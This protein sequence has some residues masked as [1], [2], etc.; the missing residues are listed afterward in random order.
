M[1]P[2][3]RSTACRRSRRPISRPGS[4]DATFVVNVGRGIVELE[5]GRKLTVSNGVFEVPDTASEIAAGARAAQGRGPVAAAAELV[6]LDRLKEASG[7]P[8]DPATSR[9]NFVGQISGRPAD[10]ERSAQERAQ[11]QHRARCL[12][13]RRRQDDDGPEGRGADAESHGQSARHA[14]QGRRAH[15]RRSRRARLSQSRATSPKPTCASRSCSTT[16]R[17]RA[18]LRHRARR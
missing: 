10:H 18:R 14:D 2:C 3:A 15:Q 5:S 6:A 1:P 12:E 11:L 13:F 7:A 4:R 17:A 8:I 16:P 9:G